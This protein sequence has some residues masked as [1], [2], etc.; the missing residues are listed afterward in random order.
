MFNRTGIISL[1]FLSTFL[2]IGSGAAASEVRVVD[3]DTIYI[4]EEKIRISG[5]DTPEKGHQAE[6]IAERMLAEL[7]TKR[8]GE[9]LEDADVAIEREGED[10]YGRTLATVFADGNT[11]A[12]MLIGEG[13]GKRWEGKQVDWCGTVKTQ[14]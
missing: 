8:L 4:G 11:V 13:L 2:L 9:Y 10:R 12:E 1:S 14:P 5:I 3:G 7:A 6:C